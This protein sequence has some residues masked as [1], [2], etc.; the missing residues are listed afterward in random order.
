MSEIEAVPPL[1][2]LDHYARLVRRTIGVPVGFVSIVGPDRQVFPG[3]QGL[4][5]PWQTARETPLTH[6]FCKYVVADAKP[7]V[8]T[9]ARQDAR[10]ATNAAVTDLGVVA[11]AGWPVTDY[12]GQ[13]VGSLCAIDVRARSWS[14]LDLENLA[15]LAVACSAELAQ[16]ELIRR[17]SVLV[18]ELERSNEHLAQLGAQISHDLQG[19]LSALSA[20]L[21]LLDDERITPGQNTPMVGAM[22]ARAQ[23]SVSRMSELLDDL[24]RYAVVGGEL[25][26]QEVDVADLVTSV[27]DDVPALAQVPLRIEQLA[28]VVADP[29]QLRLLV[30]NLLANVVKHAGGGPVEVRAHV[31]ADG[32]WWVLEVVDHGRGV[33]AADRE[34]VFAA[35]ERL[36]PSVPG[37]GLGLATCRRVVSAHGGTIV[38]DETP[39]GGTTV[40][41]RLPG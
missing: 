33:P 28:P 13:I 14:S 36:D 38:L 27:L 1:G 41:V 2:S 21:E 9:D 39:G 20:T 3:A 37:W 25:A 35:R 6:S 11:Y 19:P 12:R 18:A 24:M 17:A 8:V 40:R 10:L 15:D 5:E 30:Q 32:A 7:L 22:L 16:G 29:V 23:R 4:P 26:L 34:R 31:D